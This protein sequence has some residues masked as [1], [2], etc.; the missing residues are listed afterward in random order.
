MVSGARAGWVELIPE[1]AAEAE[2]RI[3]KRISM[4]EISALRQ[5]LNL[6]D[7][8]LRE[9]RAMLVKNTRKSRGGR[10][11]DTR[12]RSLLAAPILSNNARFGAVVIASELVNAFEEVTIKSISSYAEQ[13]GIAFENAR[14][15]K[16]SIEV[17]RYQ[18]QLKIAKEVQTQLL[19]SSLPS[20]PEIEFVSVSENADEVGG[21]YFD[22]LQA[23]PRR[24]RAAIG[25]VSGK[26][27]T[28]AF[29]MAE[30]KGIFHA[31]ARLN[32]SVREFM[33]TANQAI[34]AC[35]QRGFF[36]TFTYLEI[37]LE[38][39]V[40]RM[41][42]AGHCPAFYYSHASDT[43][44]LLREGTLGLGIVRN[45]SF[46]GMLPEAQELPCQPGD[47]LVLY[48]DGILEARNEQGE[49]FGYQRMEAVI[50]RNKAAPAPE[51][52]AA[53]IGSVKTFAHSAI[54]DDYTILIIRFKY[55]LPPPS[56]Y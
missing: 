49:E 34:S 56:P 43:L 30:I 35:M 15:I 1:G 32:L 6:S 8:M 2:V 10:H 28:A 50:Q 12:Y 55:N 24:Y 38:S 52:A 21:D 17:E 29:Y 11:Q 31:L 51:L 48:T 33:V 44:S 20:T 41:M 40:L 13:A 26:G 42:R 45:D 16:N 5:D 46:A 23:G 19:P 39:R 4:E 25:D 53:L 47:F 37:D 54:Q 36:T 18:E 22:V 14:L 9:Q 3:R 27:T 7:R